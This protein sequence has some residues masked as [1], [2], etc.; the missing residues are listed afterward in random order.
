LILYAKNSNK[1]IKERKNIE[2]NKC[3]W[4]RDNLVYHA[5]GFASGKDI[6]GIPYLI[7]YYVF[8]L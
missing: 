6:K 5:H 8:D 3:G 1:K 7:I 4:I 2:K